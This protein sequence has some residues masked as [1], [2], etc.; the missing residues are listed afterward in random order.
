MPGAGGV[1][2][3]PARATAGRSLGRARPRQRS[4]QRLERQQ[5][6]F[7]PALVAAH[8]RERA[9][10]GQDGRQRPPACATARSSCAPARSA[11]GV[12]PGGLPPR[13]PPPPPG[14]A[15]S[16]APCAPTARPGRP[17]LEI[18]RHPIAAQRVVDRDAR[19]A[20]LECAAAVPAC[21]AAARIASLIQLWSAFIGSSA[22][23]LLEAASSAS[24]SAVVVVGGE[25]GAGGGDQAEARPSAAAR[26]GGRRAGRRRARPAAGRRRAVRALGLERDH[27]DPALQARRA[28]RPASPGIWPRPSS[29]RSV[30]RSSWRSP[31]ASRAPASQR[32]AAPMP[33]AAPIGGVPASKRCGGGGVVGP[34]EA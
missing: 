25:A 22:E 3:F 21:F 20:A 1:R 4:R 23:H 7:V 11:A 8:R 15:G 6:A 17:Q 16:R 19:L 9:S 33:I 26:S 29:R 30:R 18:D 28:R 2:R 31:P 12:S 27:A 24:T 5:H 32:A 13:S 34:L 14:R 10:S